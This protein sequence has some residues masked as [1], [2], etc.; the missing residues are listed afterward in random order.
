MAVHIN[1]Y[2]GQR[3]LQSAVPLTCG[4]WNLDPGKK[5]VITTHITDLKITVV[6]KDVQETFPDCVNSHYEN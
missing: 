6:W 1:I 5:T 3:K 2:A 4:Q